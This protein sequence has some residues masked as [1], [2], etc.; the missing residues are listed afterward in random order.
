MAEEVS[1]I[2][3]SESNSVAGSDIG[4]EGVIELIDPRQS[5]LSLMLILFL[6]QSI[7]E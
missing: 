4:W 3:E 2:S 1:A 5:K 6:L 7:L